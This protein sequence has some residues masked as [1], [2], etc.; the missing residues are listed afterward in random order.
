MCTL[1]RRKLQNEA[2]GTTSCGRRSHVEDRGKWIPMRVSMPLILHRICKA[3]G[4]I[5]TVDMLDE[6]ECHIQARTNTRWRPDVP[7]HRPPCMADPFDFGTKNDGAGPGCFVRRR[8]FTIENPSSR[9]QSR[10]CAHC[11]QVSQLWV[12]HFDVIDDIVQVRCPSSETSRYNEN[13]KIRRI[14]QR[15][16]WDDTL[17]E[18]GVL[19]IRTWGAG[20][21]C[22][23]GSP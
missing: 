13:I 3:S 14:V 21:G 10:P 5:F 20:L 8:F 19:W 23:L 11:D 4:H 9:C 7:I 17:K 22:L 15:M 2:R 12:C 1:E 16:S 6:C 18:A